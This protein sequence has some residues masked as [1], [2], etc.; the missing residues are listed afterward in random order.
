MTDTHRRRAAPPPR[1]AA[2]DDDPKPRPAAPKVL[3]RD[4]DPAGPAEPAKKSIKA[5]E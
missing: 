5:K 2:S 4:P 3:P 1:S